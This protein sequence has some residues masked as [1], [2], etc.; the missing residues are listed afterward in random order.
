MSLCPWRKSRHI[1]H[2]PL[3]SRVK[4]SFIKVKDDFHLLQRWGP[5][6]QVWKSYK[7]WSA[8]Q[9]KGWMLTSNFILESRIVGTSMFFWTWSIWGDFTPIV[10]P[11]LRASVKSDIVT[12]GIAATSG[13]D[14][15]NLWY[16]LLKTDLWEIWGS[17]I[18]GDFGSPGIFY[19]LW[20][21]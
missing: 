7:A 21:M 6:R 5:G 19:L 4:R 20:L 2:L 13:S 11:F 16:L 8:R 3:G 17:R 1:S 10:F 14:W 15:L 18:L 12:T 9:K